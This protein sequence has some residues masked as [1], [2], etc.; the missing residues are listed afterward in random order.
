MTIYIP[1]WMLYTLLSLVIYLYIGYRCIRHRMDV[2]YADSSP[3]FYDFWLYWF[4]I[5]AFLTKTITLYVIFWPVFEIIAPPIRPILR[6]WDNR[7]IEKLVNR[8]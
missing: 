6:W 2:F 4:G 5:D 7:Q 8:L 3:G 1:A